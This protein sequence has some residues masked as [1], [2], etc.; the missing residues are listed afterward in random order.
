[1]KITICVAAAV[2]GT[3]GAAQSTLACGEVSITE[4]NWASAGIVTGV[5]KFVMEQGYG[6]KV[7]VVPSNTV[8]AIASVA[9]TGK[10]DTS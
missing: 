10:P 4:M 3:M 6:C 8:P 2:L 5:S 9:E 1:M 7:T